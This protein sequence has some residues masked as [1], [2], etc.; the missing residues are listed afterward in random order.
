LVAYRGDL[1]N[2]ERIVTELEWAGPGSPFAG[3]EESARLKLHAEL[4]HALCDY[5][6]A[7]RDAPADLDR[8]FAERCVRDGDTLI[9]LTTILLLIGS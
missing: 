6:D 8:D 3:L 9:T 4:R 5:F 7:I 1:G 2:F